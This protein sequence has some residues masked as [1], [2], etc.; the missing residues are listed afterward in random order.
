M[1]NNQPT[2]IPAYGAHH[3][4]HSNLGDALG[5]FA[6]LS[7]ILR[8]PNPGK[9]IGEL[10]AGLGMLLGALLGVGLFVQLGPASPVLVALIGAGWFLTNQRSES[11]KLREV[12][13]VELGRR[14][15]Y[16]NELALVAT[17]PVLAI[18]PHLWDVTEVSFATRDMVWALETR[19]DATFPAQYPSQADRRSCGQLCRCEP[20]EE[21]RCD[22]PTKLNVPNVVEQIAAK[23]G[24]ITKLIGQS[25]TDFVL[26]PPAV[27]LDT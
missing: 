15:Y 20:H 17:P 22:L 16:L 7:L 13:T 14:T 23:R 1:Y 8:A 18:V 19:W 5:V 12:L 6:L 3:H 27:L 4:H 2:R 11:N 26:G 25:G 10:V 21:H 9:A 24:R